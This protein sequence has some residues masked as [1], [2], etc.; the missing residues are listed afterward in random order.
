VG[1]VPFLGLDFDL[2]GAIAFLDDEEV[3]G[4]LVSGSWVVLDW[5]CSGVGMRE[6]SVRWIWREMASRS[7]FFVFKCGWSSRPFSFHKTFTLPGFSQS[8]G[9]LLLGSWKLLIRN[10]IAAVAIA[11]LSGHQR[12][13][14]REIRRL[15]V[16]YGRFASK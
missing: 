15:P 8:L 13:F 12:P 9:C 2:L 14:S 1:F 3:E 10:C 6:G 16:P 11:W 5:S 4:A 7:C